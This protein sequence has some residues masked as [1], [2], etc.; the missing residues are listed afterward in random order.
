M[1][2]MNEKKLLKVLFVGGAN[3]VRSIM[4]EAILNREDGDKFEAF[5]AGTRPGTQVHPYAIDLLTRMNF[6]MSRLAPKSCL[7]F[8]EP[9]ALPLD[10]VFTVC[11]GAAD[12]LDAAW[13]GNPVTGHWGL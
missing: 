6:D 8:V 3:S 1:I 2:D 5:S 9:G 12:A 4:A 11:D 10:F 7:T 13:P